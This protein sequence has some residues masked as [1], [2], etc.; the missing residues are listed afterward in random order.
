MKLLL[1][2]LVSTLVA[3]GLCVEPENAF[4]PLITDYK[5]RGFTV[6]LGNLSVYI[7]FPESG[8]GTKVMLHF[9]SVR[10]GCNFKHLVGCGLGT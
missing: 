2:F 4:G 9:I 10:K 3:P 1:A 7:A 5:E 6:P 8:D